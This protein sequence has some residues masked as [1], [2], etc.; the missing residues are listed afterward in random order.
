MYSCES[1]GW[2]NFKYDI[3]KDVKISISTNFGYGFSSYFTLLVSYK[4]IYIV[5]FSHIAHYYHANMIDIIKCTESYDVLKESWLSVFKYVRDYTNMSSNNPE[6]FIKQ[7]IAK[8]IDDMMNFLR[9]IIKNPHKHLSRFHNES[10]K[11]NEH[12]KVLRF[13]S[14]MDNNDKILFNVLPSEMDIVFQSEK[15]AE[16]TY[17][18]EKLNTY[19][20]I[21]TNIYDFINEI[22]NMTIELNHKINK[23]INSIKN[24]IDDHLVVLKNKKEEQ[25]KNLNIQKNELMIKCK[26][27]GQKLYPNYIIT[28]LY[29]IEKGIDTIKEFRKNNPRYFYLENYNSNYKENGSEELNKIYNIQIDKLNTII[30]NLFTDISWGCKNQIISTIY[31]INDSEKKNPEYIQLEEIYK[32]ICRQIKFTDNQIEVINEEISNLENQIY[33]RKKLIY[34]LSDCQSTFNN[35]LSNKA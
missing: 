21:L 34:R 17:T 30:D 11:D 16:A 12:Y 23:T 25:L 22:S 6:L 4:D 31:T 10:D 32:D 5:R 3:S 13:V 2:N 35:Y 24:S 19:G 28:D 1:I 29:Y 8:E 20:N 7:Y 33:D 9:D 15:L 27:I 14:P 18:I 26:S